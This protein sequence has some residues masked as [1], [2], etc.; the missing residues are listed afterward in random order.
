[1]LATAAAGVF[2]VSLLGIATLFAIK[3]REVRAGHI[4]VPMLREAGDEQA[5]AFKGF[6]S[7]RREQAAML[8]PRAAHALR[9][10]MHSSA[11]SVATFARFV[12]RHAH[13]LADRASHKYR[14][15]RRESSNDFLRKVRDYKHDDL[16]LE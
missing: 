7:R 12:E 8:P 11:L 3:Y 5:L 4:L 14:F 6:L 16:P 10:L 2:G 15:E 1:M 9:R 13:R